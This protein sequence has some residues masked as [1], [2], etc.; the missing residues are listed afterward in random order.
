MSSPFRHVDLLGDIHVVIK[1]KDWY[2]LAD[3][4]ETIKP[5]KFTHKRYVMQKGGKVWI[6]TRNKLRFVKS[7]FAKPSY[8]DFN[9][10]YF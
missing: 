4:L 10:E 6:D 2:Y 1:G 7:D 9:E 5:G 8:T 3:T